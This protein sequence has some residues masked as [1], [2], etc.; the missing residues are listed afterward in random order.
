MPQY[1]PNKNRGK[2]FGQPDLDE[3]LR[4]WNRKLARLLGSKGPEEPQNPGNGPA[5][6]EGG[7]LFK[8]GAL[9]VICVIVG[10]W[11]LTGLYKVDERESG[12]VLRLGS[13]NRI[14]GAGLH[15]H[16]PYPF[17]KRE[18][19]NVTEVRNVEVGFRG[20]AKERVK[21]EALMLTEDQNIIDMQLAVQYNIKDPKAFLFNNLSSDRVDAKDIVK[22]AVETAVREVVGRHKIDFVLNEGRAD[23][24]AKTQALI[25]NILD[26]YKVG[27]QIIKVNINDVQPPEAVQAAFDDAVKAG[28]DKEKLRN[29]GRAYANDVVPKAKGLAAKLVKEAEGY[30][31]SVVANAQGDASRFNQV[32]AEYGKGPKVMRDRLYFDMMQQVFSSTTKV[33][34]DQKSGNNLLYLPLDK[35]I[36]ATNPTTLPSQ[37]P[38]PAVVPDEPSTTDVPSEATEQPASSAPGGNNNSRSKNRVRDFLG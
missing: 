15:W 22:Q 23:I 13:F 25:Q 9:T 30:K 14:T 34:V 21:E 31:L 6:P 32:V 33:L 5:L 36:N 16:L 28:Q 1:D 2:G 11:L 17:E 3:L 29:E 19:V 38:K 7:R 10:L 27:V 26:R 4:Q 37:Q 8:G 35:L 12:V 24:Q 18:I 20:S